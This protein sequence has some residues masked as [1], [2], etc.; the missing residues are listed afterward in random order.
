MYLFSNT[1]MDIVILITSIIGI[2]II[3]ITTGF[4]ILVKINRKFKVER[5][6]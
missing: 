4:V 2:A 3:L 1:G 6:P 5:E